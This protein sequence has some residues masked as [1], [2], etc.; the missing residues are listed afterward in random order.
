MFVQLHPPCIGVIAVDKSWPMHRII[1]QGIHKQWESVERASL[2]SLGR[3]DASQLIN[4][5]WQ[6]PLQEAIGALS[7]P[8][9]RCDARCLPPKEGSVMTKAA[10]LIKRFVAI[11]EKQIALAGDV[12]AAMKKSETAGLTGAL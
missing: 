11:R 5:T 8:V 7:P 12:R 6:P 2:D 4:P 3:S 9:H 1:G 10:P